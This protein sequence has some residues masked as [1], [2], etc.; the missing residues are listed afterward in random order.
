MHVLEILRPRRRSSRRIRLVAGG[1]V[2]LVGAPAQ[3]QNAYHSQDEQ[4]EVKCFHVASSYSV[5]QG[6]CELIQG[7]S[8]IKQIAVDLRWSL[9]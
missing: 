6:S 1:L 9:N 2:W 5:S 3:T 8:V 4:R 7:A